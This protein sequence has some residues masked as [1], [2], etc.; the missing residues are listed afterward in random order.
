MISELKSTARARE[1]KQPVITEYPLI[2]SARFEIALREVTSIVQMAAS[3]SPNGQLPSSSRIVCY[4]ECPLIRRSSMTTIFERLAITSTLICSEDVIMM[5]MYFGC[6][7]NSGQV[8]VNT[9]EQKVTLH[10]PEN[11]VG[12]CLCACID[13]VMLMEMIWCH[14]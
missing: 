8:L 10:V 3:L 2:R 14:S 5:I 6:G 4:L 9:W 1:T 11:L 12:G 13:V 7:I